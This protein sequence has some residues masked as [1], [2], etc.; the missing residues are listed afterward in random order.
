[1]GGQLLSN[2]CCAQ[3]RDEHLDLNRLSLTYMSDPTDKFVAQTPFAVTHV[4]AFIKQV[5]NAHFANHKNDGS[6]T[7][8][9]L[10]QLLKTPVWKSSHELGESKKIFEQ[11]LTDYPPEHFSFYL[12]LL[13]I[14]WCQGSDQDKAKQLLKI[15]NPPNQLSGKIASTDKEL[16]MAIKGIFELSINFTVR[17]AKENERTQP[18]S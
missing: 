17:L 9:L 13:A 8:D 7:L 6:L 2:L 16:K 5:Q 11:I 14:L 15:I 1:M 18:F 4:N 3:S 12:K 10:M